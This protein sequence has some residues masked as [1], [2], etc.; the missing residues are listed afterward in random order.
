M[1]TGQII[2]SIF[3]LPPRLFE[4]FYVRVRE[5]DGFLSNATL[6]I[7]FLIFLATSFYWFFQKDLIFTI[8]SSTGD[9]LKSA[10]YALGRSLSHNPLS[11]CVVALIAL[12]TA[13]LSF[14]LFVSRIPFA[15][16]VAA[17]FVLCASFIY[18]AMTN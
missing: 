2:K 12:I 13:V 7:T 18:Y 14:R 6:V 16:F 11:K 8:A 3:T 15:L 9:P 5:D 10:F 1:P 17:P 4:P